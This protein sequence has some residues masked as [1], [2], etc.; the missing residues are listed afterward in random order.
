MARPSA[1][2]TSVASRP[3]CAAPERLRWWDSMRRPRTSPSARTGPTC[4]RNG[5]G[6]GTGSK[7]MARSSRPARSGTRA[8]LLG[9]VERHAHDR[10]RDALLV[11]V[12]LADLDLGAGLGVL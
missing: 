10:G 11:A 6:S 1:K 8:L 3:P 4:A 9:V 5:P 7:G 2:S 12:E